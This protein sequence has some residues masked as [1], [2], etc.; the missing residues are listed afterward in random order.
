M[1]D[2]VPPLAGSPIPSSVNLA[3]TS[4]APTAR[5]IA[6]A[7]TEIP[8]GNSLPGEL[9]PAW[10]EQGFLRSMLGDGDGNIS[11]MRVVFFIVALIIAL[12]WAVI[13]IRAGALQPLPSGVPSILAILT[14][15]KLW[16][17]SQENQIPTA[18]E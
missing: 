12:T 7:P 17:N 6:G 2:A 8:S 11:S 5:G 10:V 14:G 4:G 18:E 15:G 9:L 13:S 3:G 16:Q 1:Q